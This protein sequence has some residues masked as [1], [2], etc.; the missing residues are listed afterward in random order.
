MERAT[1]HS[2]T[3]NSRVLDFNERTTTSLRGWTITMHLWLPRNLTNGSFH[4]CG[5]ETEEEQ[6]SG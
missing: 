6:G 5:V 2:T 4:L 1:G 3:P